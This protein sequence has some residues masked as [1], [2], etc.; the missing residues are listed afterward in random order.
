MF[1]KF[2][3]TVLTST[4]LDN[5]VTSTQTN[6]NSCINE[7]ARYNYQKSSEIASGETNKWYVVS[8]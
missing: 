8:L 7:C 3:S 2:C 1:R 4:G 5:V 6:L